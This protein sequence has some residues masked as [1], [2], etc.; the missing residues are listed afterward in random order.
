MAS[1]L[2]VLFLAPA[3][4]RFHP[5][6]GTDP[7]GPQQPDPPP[8]EPEGEEGTAL[9]QPGAAPAPTRPSRAGPAAPLGCPDFT[10]ADI[11]RLALS[12][13]VLLIVGLILAEAHYSRPR[14]VS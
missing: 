4:A 9:I 2:T 10:H 14:V 11:A 3:H 13:M 6:E 12:A 8:T 5:T 1:A 7:A